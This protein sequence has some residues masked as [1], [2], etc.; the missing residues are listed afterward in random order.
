[1][2]VSQTEPPTLGIAGFSYPDLF[3]PYGLRRLFDAWQGELLASDPELGARYAS[4]R[5]GE[6]R[7]A[8]SLST[9][10]C[11]V[12]PYVSRF[13]I[14]LFP[15]SAP[16]LLRIADRSIDSTTAATVML[17][18]S[19]TPIGPGDGQPGDTW[20]VLID[21]LPRYDYVVPNGATTVAGIAT[22]LAKLINDRTVNGGHP[23]TAVADGAQF[24]LATGRP[25]RWIAPV[26]DGLGMLLHQAVPED[27]VG[28]ALGTR[29]ML[30]GSAQ[31]ASRTH[32]SV[33]YPGTRSY[34]CLLT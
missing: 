2:A 10:L 21:E 34:R 32:P 3:S 12:A 1:M 14:R 17:A 27:R 6:I 8:E 23:F 22:E 30:V 28:E 13:L 20:S 19:G 26:V 31:A 4:Y 7:D 11:Q 5:A 18:L 25:P 33:R 24:V 9:L 16:P 15:Q 29:L